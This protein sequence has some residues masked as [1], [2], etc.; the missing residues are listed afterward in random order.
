MRDLPFWVTFQSNAALVRRTQPLFQTRQFLERLDFYPRVMTALHWKDFHLTPSFAIRETHYG[1]RKVN[2]SIVD[3]N[4]NRHVQEVAVDLALPTLARIFEGGGWLGEKVKHVIEPRL[5]FRH[6]RGIDNFDEYIRFDETELLSNTTEADISITNRLYV[7]RKGV[8]SEFLSWQLWQRRYFDTD[9]GG[10]IVPGKKNVVRSAVDMTGYSYL[11]QPRHYSPIV[12]A[13]R[14]APVPGLGIE[15]RT[16]YDPFRRRF[17]NSGI[18]ADGR[19][20][21]YFVSIGHNYI[22]SNPQ[23]LTPSANQVRGL[24]GIGDVNRRGW[25]AAFTA[26]YDFR[27]AQMQYS[28]TQVTYNT[29]CCGFSVT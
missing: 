3:Q 10:A 11:D 2:T 28:T 9:F 22:R 12:S 20:S 14:V 19:V 7:K 8:V 23:L 15:W 4:I 25:N 6:V 1:E 13:M 27:L 16:D 17:V 21:Q 18:T 24:I 29:D 26:I 5:G